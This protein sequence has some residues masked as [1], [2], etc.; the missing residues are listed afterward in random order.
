MNCVFWKGGSINCVLLDLALG[1]HPHTSHQK[2]LQT[3][4]LGHLFV[5][6]FLPCLRARFSHPFWLC[7][8]T[9][10][11]N[12]PPLRCGAGG[13]SLIAPFKFFGYDLGAHPFHN[14]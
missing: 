2:S 12:P 6:F 8:R 13:G 1:K 14:Y 7:L 5:M 4:L 11:M 10:L 9:P 3:D